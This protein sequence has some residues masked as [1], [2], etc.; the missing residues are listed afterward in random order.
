[1]KMKTYIFDSAAVSVRKFTR[2]AWTVLSTVL[3]LVLVSLALFIALYLVF[4]LFISTDTE[5]NLRREN[6]LYEKAFADIPARQK[7][8]SEFAF[9]G[10]Q[11]DAARVAAQVVSG[12]GFIGAGVRSRGLAGLP[13][14]SGYHPRREDSHLHHP[15]GRCPAADGPQGG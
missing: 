15:Q 1:M 13:F 2:S 8:L 9:E 10:K 6:K 12:I 5:K 11:H 4:S 14:R 7:L 3:R